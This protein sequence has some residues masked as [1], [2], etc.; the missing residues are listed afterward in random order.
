MGLKTESVVSMVT[1]GPPS[2]FKTHENV[3]NRKASGKVAGSII[4]AA[5]MYLKEL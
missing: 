1:R 2:R 4:K 3:Q 5:V